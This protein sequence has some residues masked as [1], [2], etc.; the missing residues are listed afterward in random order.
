MT[1]PL[2]QVHQLA[3]HW[4][5]EI[6]PRITTPAGFEMGSGIVVNTTTPEQAIRE[7]RSDLTDS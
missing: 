1:P 4:F 5:I 2:D 3:N 7:L 6:N